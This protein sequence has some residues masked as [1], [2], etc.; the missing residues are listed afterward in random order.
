MAISD[1][2]FSFNSENPLGFSAWC[3]LTKL[4]TNPYKYS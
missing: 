4:V 1:F 2:L 3:V